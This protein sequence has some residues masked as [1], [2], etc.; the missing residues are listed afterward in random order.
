MKRELALASLAWLTACASI[1][2]TTTE[3]VGVPH[4][5]PGDPKVVQILRAEPAQPLDRLG[6]I[7]IDA[8]VDPAPP[9]EDVEQRL[10]EEA[11]KLGASAVVIV[12]DRVQPVGVVVSG[13][14]WAPAAS[15]VTG[16]RLVGIAV[17]YR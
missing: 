16:R 4:F 10:R 5:P 3:Y 13:P 12:F 1:D 8:S 7:M 9:I 2:A 6:E 11:A 17:R 15:P 14:Y